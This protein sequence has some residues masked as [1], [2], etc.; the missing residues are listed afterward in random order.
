MMMDRYSLEAIYDQALVMEQVRRYAD[1]MQQFVESFGP[2]PT[3]LFRSPGRINLIGEHTDYN[4]GFVMPVALDKDVLFV[5]RPRQDPL[6]RATNME[7]QFPPFS[8]ELSDDIPTA[9]RGSWSNY[10][11]GAGQEICRQF[12]DRTPIRGMDVMVSGAVPHGVPRGSGVSS[13]TAL[14]VTV[15]LALVTLNGIDIERPHLAHLSSEAE[16]YVG[17]RGGMMDQFSSLLS[18]RDHALFLDCRPSSEGQYDL[19]HVP[20]P[21]NVQ[22]VLLHSGVRHRNV[23]NQFN[24]RVAECKIG[25]RLLQSQYPA[26]THLRDVTP[27]ALGLNDIDFWGLIEEELP[28]AATAN[29]LIQQGV[30]DVWLK[31]LIADHQLDA[32]ATF[33]VLPR[34]RHVLTENKRVLSGIAALNAGEVEAFGQLMNVAHDSMRDDYAASCREVDTLVEI[35]RQQPPVLGARVT[36]AGWGGSVVALVRRAGG[37]AWIGDACAAYRQATGLECEILICRPGT[38]AGQVRYPSQQ[39]STRTDRPTADGPTANEL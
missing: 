15:A 33:A 18:R 29:E 20:I 7:A 32:D 26:I 27:E 16:W 9:P 36:G 5:V 21:P 35:I 13:S 10:F 11:R 39:A 4:G 31:E 25:V 37:T 34:C 1:A 24:Q 12:G 23:R 19:H 14:T 17:T 3:V 38:G 2:G 28:T 30:N 6:I 22:I 8:F